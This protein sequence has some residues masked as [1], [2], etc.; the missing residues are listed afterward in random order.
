MQTV[1]MQVQS[2]LQKL[3]DYSKRIGLTDPISLDGLIESHSHLRNLNLENRALLN[4]EMER[5]R[6]IAIANARAEVQH[7]EYISIE[8]L[9]TM[10]ISEISELVASR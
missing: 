6:N 9:Q 10:T 8:K 7:G 1:D 3:I 5:C 4:E 2:V